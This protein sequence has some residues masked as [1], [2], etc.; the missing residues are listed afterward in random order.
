MSQ[1][2][3]QHEYFEPITIRPYPHL[4]LRT[5]DIVVTASIAAFPIFVA[6]ATADNGWDRREV[7]AIIGFSIFVI[8]LR[9][10]TLAI[11]A[12]LRSRT[13]YDLKEHTLVVVRDDTRIASFELAQLIGLRPDSVDRNGVGSVDLPRQPFK[14]GR[15]M[16]GWRSFVPSLYADDA[17]TL[18]PDIVQLCA[19]IRQHGQLRSSTAHD[20]AVALP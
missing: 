9:C 10:V 15:G 11:D 17:L 3:L 2:T 8:V 7:I 18:I 6:I 12:D 20:F 4:Y 1:D 14:G 16:N 5:R 19:T 13:R